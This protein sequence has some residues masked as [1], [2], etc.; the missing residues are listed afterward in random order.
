MK[1][2]RI[3][4]HAALVLAGA[5]GMALPAQAKDCEAK[6][7]ATMSEGTYR[8]LDRI[9]GMIAEDNYGEAEERLNRMTDRGNKYEKAVVHQT[10][11]FVFIQQED[12][13]RGLAA[14]EQALAFDALP[15][16]SLIHI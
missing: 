1:P 7:S 2:S 15:V 4:R 10:L 11:G 16:L 12:Y 13:K 3:W 8:A 5:L 6:N 14:F 9:H